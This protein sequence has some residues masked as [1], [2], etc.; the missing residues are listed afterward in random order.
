[1]GHNDSSN[2]VLIDSPTRMNHHK[3]NK[4]LRVLYQF[5]WKLLFQAVEKYYKKNPKNV[6]QEF[7][8]AY[9]EV[10]KP[11]IFILN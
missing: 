9:L 4:W 1:M 10:N 6:S 5:L 8:N 3:S 11:Y 2:V 7:R